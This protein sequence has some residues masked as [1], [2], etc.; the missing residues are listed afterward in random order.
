MFIQ[1]MSGLWTPDWPDLPADL[2]DY[3]AAMRIEFLAAR[4]GVQGA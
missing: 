4:R 2:A 3:L 1:W